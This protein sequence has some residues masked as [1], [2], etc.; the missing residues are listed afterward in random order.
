[1]AVV[2]HCRRQARVSIE[3]TA[4]LNRLGASNV[5]AKPPH[6]PPPRAPRQRARSARPLAPHAVLLTSLCL[7]LHLSAGGAY[8]ADVQPLH[9]THASVL[10]ACT[11]IL[12]TP[13]DRPPSE[14]Q[15]GAARH[16]P[17]VSGGP[18][19]EGGCLTEL[20]SAE[21]LLRAQPPHTCGAGAAPIRS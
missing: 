18:K 20:I 16:H 3:A 12:R 17:Q 2:G 7:S 19:E 14:I 21:T 13:E 1:M 6:H 8:G 15:H 4:G 11:R 5:Q 10:R 9:A